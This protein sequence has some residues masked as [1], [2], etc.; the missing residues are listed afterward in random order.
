MEVVPVAQYESDV[1]DEEVVGEDHGIN[2]QKMSFV[3][4]MTLRK[5][6]IY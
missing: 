4:Q 6:I 1:S 2:Q 3:F 5:Y